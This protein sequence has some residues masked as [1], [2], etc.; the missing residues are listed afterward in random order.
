MSAFDS[1]N[2]ND[3]AEVTDAIRR[4]TTALNAAG[5]PP[6]RFVSQRQANITT[7]LMGLFPATTPVEPMG[8]ADA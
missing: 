3:L 4:W 7:R 5:L 1:L 2:E 6:M 8:E